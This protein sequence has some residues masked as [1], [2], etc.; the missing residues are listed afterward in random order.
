MSRKLE[1]ATPSIRADQNAVTY[2]EV[3]TM[4]RRFRDDTKREVCQAVDGLSS[5][6]KALE[7]QLV[8]VLT[9]A[10]RKGTTLQRSFAHFDR[11]RSG[12]ISWWSSRTAAMGCFR[13]QNW[14]VSVLLRK[15]DSNGDGVI[16]LDEFLALF[17]EAE[18]FYCQRADYDG[19]RRGRCLGGR[20]GYILLGRGPRSVGGGCF[21]SSTR[22]ALGRRRP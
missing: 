18:H 10:E 4:V 20:I 19:P 16:S 13:G 6:L 9:K 3:L 8:R 22:M 1:P 2:D 14:A 12:T 5:N 15:F 21:A 7:A 11:D 17:D